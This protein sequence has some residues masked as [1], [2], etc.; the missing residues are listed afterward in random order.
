MTSALQGTKTYSEEHINGF[1]I[2]ADD[3]TLA[4]VGEK[5]HYIF[6]LSPGFKYIL[7]SEKRSKIRPQFGD[8]YLLANAGVA[9]SYT[10]S[11]STTELNDAEQSALKNAGFTQVKNDLVLKG[12]LEGQYFTAKRIDNASA[13]S[14]PYAI[15]LVKDSSLPAPVKVALTP[16]TVAADGVLWIGGAALISL[17]CVGPTVK[18]GKCFPGGL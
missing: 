16:I 15:N 12:Q 10:L 14:R 2:S 6:P 1:Y 3:K 8:F 18:G 9:G 5:Y 4:I 17:F 7:T 11:I 13:F